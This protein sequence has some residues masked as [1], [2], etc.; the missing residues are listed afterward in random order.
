MNNSGDR[1]EEMLLNWPG[2][3]YRWLSEP[4]KRTIRSKL[5]LIM[6]C[7]S[8]IPIIVVTLLA[9]DN[10]RKVMEQEVIQSNLTR[11]AWSGEAVDKNLTQINNLIYTILISPAFNEYVNE[12]EGNLSDSFILQRNVINT[13]TS[14]FYSGYYSLVEIQLYFKDKNKLFTLNDMRNTIQTPIPEA[15]MWRD[16]VDQK[17]DFII[18]DSPGSE[19]DFRLIRSINR[20]ENK[21]K[22]GSI[23]FDAKWR[24]MDNALELLNSEQESGV[25][26]VGAGDKVMYQLKEGTPPA[27]KGIDPS[28]QE[29]GYVRTSDHYVFYHYLEPWGLTL[30]KVLPASYVNHSASVTQKY[31]LIVGVLSAL[32]S[33]VIAAFVAYRVSGPIIRLARSMSGLNWLKGEG[34]PN[35]NRED[36]I[37]MLEKR[38]KTMSSRIREHIHNEYIINLEKQTAQLK[39]LQAQINPHFLQNTLQLIGSMAYSKKPSDIY[40]VIQSLSDMFRY[41]IRDPGELTTLGKEIKHLNNYM[42]IQQQRYADKLNYEVE[43]PPMWQDILVPKLTLHPLVENA[44]MHGFDRKKGAWNLSLR[45][46]PYKNGL[47]LQVEDNGMGIPPARLE[48]VRAR[49]AEPL[50]PYWTSG[51]SIGLYNVSARIKLYFGENYGLMID[52]HPAGGARVSMYIPIVKVGDQHEY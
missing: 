35:S 30:I 43:I 4:F 23:Q 20:F 5:I 26:I 9:T 28:K 41:T 3:I 44:F 22:I 21:E 1:G 10:T 42:H 50:D 48:E 25:Y 33:A 24:M 40:S 8:V 31:G 12:D 46:H 18:K 51:N 49:L 6:L 34:L 13:M 2:R 32:L 19:S 39:A 36:E 37:G 15:P 45:L 52:N 17:A 47:L 7:I 14:I 38:F 16:L 29:T 27:M 11:I